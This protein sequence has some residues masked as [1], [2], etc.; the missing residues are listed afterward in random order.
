MKEI[1]KY[2]LPAA[3]I[4]ALIGAFSSNIAG[5]EFFIFI[6]LIF[7]ALLGFLTVQRKENIKVIIAYLGLSAV[8]GMLV[9]VPLVGEFVT[10]FFTHLLAIFGI[11]VLVVSFK[12]LWKAFSK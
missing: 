4:L 11:A 8:S 10:A 7:G 2:L 5:M 3:I 1:V 6:S 9:V 12:I